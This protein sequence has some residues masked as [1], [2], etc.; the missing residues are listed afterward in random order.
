M[1]SRRHTGGVSCEI[2]EIP[3]EASFGIRHSHKFGGPEIHTGSGAHS[4]LLKAYLA[5]TRQSLGR[6]W[7]LILLLGLVFP[8]IFTI[9]ELASPLLA[10]LS[11]W[12]PSAWLTCAC[13]HAG[14]LLMA[15]AQRRA[16]TGGEFGSFLLSL[17]IDPA[18]RWRACV[19]ALGIANLPL[20]AYF[21]LGLSLAPSGN[22]ALL[23]M[24]L[25]CATLSVV[26]AQVFWLNRRLPEV[27][28][29]VAVSSAAVPS[30]A[31]LHSHQPIAMALCLLMCLA[32]WPALSGHWPGQARRAG[33]QASALSF[34]AATAMQGLE[35]RAPPALRLTL[36]ALSHH[37]RGFTLQRVLLAALPCYLALLV[38]RAGGA[39]G[40]EKGLIVI[41]TA[42]SSWPMGALFRRL[43]NNREAIDLYLSTLPVRLGPYWLASE[44]FSVTL[45]G[46]VAILP[47]HLLLLRA[48]HLHAT[49]LAWLWTGLIV[50][51]VG[52]RATALLEGGLYIVI[53]MLLAWPWSAAMIATLTWMS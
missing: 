1:D 22:M 36:R 46:A 21:C 18:V 27:L 39:V 33:A 29:L 42:C 12:S 23:T 28:V 7:Q 43:R 47:L 2:I 9:H 24:Q 6:W 48:G 44:T 19:T 11:D 13:L 4:Y 8:Q 17:P 45:M 38:L 49:D 37:H 51:L 53:L 26:A 10:A 5:E 40:S 16:L 20:L 32:L 41:A 25:V 34:S 3:G 52:V 31:G 30:L 15:L 35:R 50:L 14:A